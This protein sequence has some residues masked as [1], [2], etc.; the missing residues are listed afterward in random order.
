VGENNVEIK[1]Y[2]PKGAQIKV[3]DVKTDTV[4]EATKKY[5]NDK[6]TVKIVYDIKIISED[7]EY[8]PTDF[9]EN[10]EVT[11]TGL[12]QV[13]TK[14][15]KYKILHIKEDNTAEEIEKIETK[16]NGVTFETNHFSTYA[17]M[18]ED[19][20]SEETA[21]ALADEPVTYAIGD[22]FSSSADVW[23]GSV[24]SGFPQGEGTRRKTLF[25]YVSGRTCLLSP[26][27]K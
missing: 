17:V 14:K 18:L 3:D 12:E 4:Q 20:A 7:K 23:D 15:Q 10:V 6:T 26:T 5:M 13:D 27:S 9:D 8:E 22:T 25:N 2:M 1:G 16:E 21:T 24:A 19:V 11:I